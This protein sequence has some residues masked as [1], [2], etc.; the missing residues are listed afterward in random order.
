MWQLLYIYMYVMSDFFTKILSIFLYHTI[1]RQLQLYREKFGL[2]DLKF[3]YL[4]TKNLQ[5]TVNKNSRTTDLQLY[6]DQTGL[7]W[8]KNAHCIQMPSSTYTLSED[9]V[10]LSILYWP[11]QSDVTIWHKPL[12]GSLVSWTLTWRSPRLWILVS[13]RLGPEV[14]GFLHTTLTSDSGDLFLLYIFPPIA[15]KNRIFTVAL[16]KHSLLYFI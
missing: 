1:H 3:S 15:E 16:L 5:F 6:R 9:I 10:I 4:H 8:Q 7:N 2:T 11:F 12:S 14:S 13:W